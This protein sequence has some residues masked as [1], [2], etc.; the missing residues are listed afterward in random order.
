MDGVGVMIGNLPARSRT[1]SHLPTLSGIALE[2]ANEVPG[3]GRPRL[4][5]SLQ[6][7]ETDVLLIG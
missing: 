7:I 6:F 3:L 1:R 2:P 4:P 5:E